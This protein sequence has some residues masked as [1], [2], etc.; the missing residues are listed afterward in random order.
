MN[1]K[2]RRRASAIEQ[3]AAS[4]SRQKWE[5]RVIEEFVGMGWTEN[6]VRSHMRYIKTL[7]PSAVSVIRNVTPLAYVETIVRE[8][9]NQAETT[10]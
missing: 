9:L 10:K 5:N 3:K 1:R 8:V 2:Q 7:P 6:Q 4:K